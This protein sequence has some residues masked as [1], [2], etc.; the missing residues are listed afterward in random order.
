[1][2]YILK[3]LNLLEKKLKLK[4]IYLIILIAISS[5]CELLVLNSFLPFVIKFSNS[6]EPINLGLMKYLID[7]DNKNYNILFY[8]L[9]F[10]I[11]I[12]LSTIIRV[13]AFNYQWNIIYKISNFVSV[14][15][16]ELS[17]TQPFEIHKN[18]ST[19]ELSSDILNKVNN[20]AGDLLNPFFSIVSS[21]FLFIFIFSFLLYINF[22]VILSTASIICVIYFCITF[23]TKV[24]VMKL[25]IT[26][27]RESTSFFKVVSESFNNIENI[28]INN[29][30]SYYIKFYKETL[31]RLNKAQK[32]ILFIG[33]S[34][35]YIIESF[36]LI[37]IT[38]LICFYTL[39]P[40][41]KSIIPI[42]S[43]IVLGVQRT[44]PS[45]QYFYSGILHIRSNKST[46]EKVF[47]LLDQKKIDIL[48]NSKA[49]SFDN[50][51]RFCDVNF[52][53]NSRNELILKNINF[54]IN[55]GDKIG[56][57]GVSGSGKTTLLNLLLGLVAPSTGCITIDDKNIHS[58]ILSY[59][60]KISFVP[61]KVYLHEATFFDNITQSFISDDVNE[62]TK[63]NKVLSDTLLYKKV[64]SYKNNIFETIGQGGV[65]L[66]GG[67]VQRIGIARA[68][69]KDADILI[70]DEATNSL[71]KETE[72]QIINFILNQSELTVVLVSHDDSN[73]VNCTRI[74][75]IDD[76]ELRII[77]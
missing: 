61:Q 6:G 1:M 75:E 51:L 35:R 5:F 25:S 9:I 45:L 64:Y 55:K 20:I 43:V 34:P 39:D 36:A 17:L 42:F 31:L 30:Y 73:F 2:I 3:L 50:K 63:V 71:D 76:G 49:L 10:S 27:S 70:L 33:S 56:I 21:V 41:N 77:K 57:K 60:K 18:R 72:N 44:L 28:I 54:E 53:Y 19:T 32:N 52:S 8:G 11:V 66:S 58:N 67:Q 69:F 65:L 15:A 74:Y 23:F 59:Y 12:I 13:F 62:I 48:V 24:Y 16:Y 29:K 40:N 22:V 46:L 4:I 38:F 14:T 26:V 47:N 68:L 37:T 7:I